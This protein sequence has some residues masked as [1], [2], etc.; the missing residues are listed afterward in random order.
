ML[1]N[2]LKLIRGSILGISTIVGVS[3]LILLTS[4]YQTVELTLDYSKNYQLN[5]KITQFG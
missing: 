4:T 2:V 5:S 3:L 1:V